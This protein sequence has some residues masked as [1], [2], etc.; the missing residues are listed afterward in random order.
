MSSRVR[1][2]NSTGGSIGLSKNAAAPARSA[3][4]PDLGIAQPG[5]Q[6]GGLGMATLPQHL[7]Q[8]DSVHARHIDI[9]HQDM[10]RAFVMVSNSW[11]EPKTV[12]SMPFS[13]R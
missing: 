6:H 3:L 11:A 10:G 7:R 1:A 13:V 2:E 5:D 9:E 4:R 8:R 12:T